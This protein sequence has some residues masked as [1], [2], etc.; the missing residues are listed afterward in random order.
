M[1]RLIVP[2]KAPTYKEVKW[3][4]AAIYQGA[5]PAAIAH[6]TSWTQGNCFT[7][8]S[9]KSTSLFSSSHLCVH[10]LVYQTSFQFYY[11]YK[12]WYYHYIFAFKKIVI[13]QS[14]ES[15]VQKLSLLRPFQFWNSIMCGRLNFLVTFGKIRIT[16]QTRAYPIVAK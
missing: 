11:I 4:L 8:S 13:L 16:R 12:K 2:V 5:P 10:P 15:L 6:R 14:W 7:I 1:E 3:G 9:L